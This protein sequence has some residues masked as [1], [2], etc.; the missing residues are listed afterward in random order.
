MTEELSATMQDV[1]LSVNT[2]NDNADA[3]RKDVEIIATKSEDINKFSKELKKQ[4]Y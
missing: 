4:M 1:G 3:I 2:I